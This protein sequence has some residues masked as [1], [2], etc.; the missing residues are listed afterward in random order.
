MRRVDRLGADDDER[1]AGIKEALHGLLAADAAADL[2]RHAVRRLDDLLDRLEVHRRAFQRAVEVDHVQALRALGDKAPRHFGG[3]VGKH[4]D[5]VHAAL[6]QAHA[7]AVLE[8][9]CWD[10]KHDGG[11]EE[12][13]VRLGLGSGSARQ[14]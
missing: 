8:V 11:R 12:A 13:G 1:H 10:Q 4:R 9:D 3:V 2:H 5:V 14:D 6:P 7:L